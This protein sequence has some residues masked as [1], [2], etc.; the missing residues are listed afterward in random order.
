MPRS[1]L[2]QMSAAGV[3]KDLIRS[4]IPDSRGTVFYPMLQRYLCAMLAQCKAMVHDLPGGEVHTCRA[5][6]CS[7]RC[8]SFV[9]M[10]SKIIMTATFGR[11]AATVSLTMVTYMFMSLVSHCNASFPSTRAT[12]PCAPSPSTSRETLR[13]R[14][15][16][17]M[18][19][20]MTR[21]PAASLQHNSCSAVVP[22][23]VAIPCLIRA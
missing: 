12:S 17:T 10:R 7:R 16:M 19:L 11:V 1:L 20:L 22:Y 14:L 9:M 23:V 2:R 15:G 4:Q 18:S 21:V 6:R 8:R 3:V 13:K 5:M